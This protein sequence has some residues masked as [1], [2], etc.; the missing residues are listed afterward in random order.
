MHVAVALAL[1]AATAIAVI[2]T[3]FRKQWAHFYAKDEAVAQT[4]VLCMPLLSVSLVFDRRVLLPAQA[5]E[6]ISMIFLG[7]ECQ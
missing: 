5:L 7:L 4:V 3:V 2:L 1:A 6:L